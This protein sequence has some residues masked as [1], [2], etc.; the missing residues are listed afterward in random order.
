[1][2]LTILNDF[3]TSGT[4]DIP[5]EE[6]E[7]FE[8]W[9]DILGV[10]PDADEK[11]IKRAYREVAKKHHPDKNNGDKESEEKFKKAAE[12]YEILSDPEKRKAFDEKR[13]NSKK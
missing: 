3:A 5:Q 1:L 8:D 11:E 9:Y 6:E 12:A 13:K 4:E 7:I 2:L 10:E